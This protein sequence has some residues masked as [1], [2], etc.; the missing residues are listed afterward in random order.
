MHS[1]RELAGTADAHMLYRILRR[2]FGTLRL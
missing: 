2:F 1:I